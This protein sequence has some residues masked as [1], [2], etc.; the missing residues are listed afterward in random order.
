MAYEEALTATGAM[1]ELYETFGSYQGDWWAKVLYNGS[2]GWVHGT[3]GSCSGCDA[4]ESEVGYSGKDT[5][6]EHRYDYPKPTNC[7]ACEVAKKDYQKRL[8]EFGKC[9]LESIMTQ[10][11]AE[12]EAGKEFA[13]KYDKEAVKE[14]VKFLQDN[15]CDG[16][17]YWVEPAPEPE[18][19]EETLEATSDDYEDDGTNAITVKQ[20]LSNLMKDYS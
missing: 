14:T 19:D 8:V 11:E 12:N 17:I 13:W 5:C 3:Y 6:D 18:D 2:L 15:T 16:K 7:D 20:V 1:V 9:Y 4:F 10:A